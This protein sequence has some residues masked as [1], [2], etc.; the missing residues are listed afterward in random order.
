MPRDIKTA[1]EIRAEVSRVVHEMDLVK[2][3]KATITVYD[4]IPLAELDP[5]GC[6]WSMHV[7]GNA[8]GYQADCANALQI[9]QAKW[10]L[11]S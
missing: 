4:P 11:K 1:A 9:V 8:A 10:N 5:T 7:F 3:D 6:N 2:E